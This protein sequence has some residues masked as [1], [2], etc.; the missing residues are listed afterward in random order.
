MLA[1]KIE[2]YLRNAWSDLDLTVHEGIEH[3]SKI[4]SVITEIGNTKLINVLKPEEK[5]EMLLNRIHVTLPGIL[6]YREVGVV[7]RNQLVERR[8]RR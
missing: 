3:L 5:I 1:Y 4:S 7:T 8:E 6:P 2:R